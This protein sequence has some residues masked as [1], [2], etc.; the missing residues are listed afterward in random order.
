MLRSRET[1]FNLRLIARI[2][3]SVQATCFP[4]VQS[5]KFREKSWMLPMF[6]K[7]QIKIR[8]VCP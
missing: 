7:P 4:R 1:H 3:S 5:L 2:T 8:S 6:E